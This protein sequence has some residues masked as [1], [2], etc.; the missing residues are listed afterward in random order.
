MMTA[1]VGFAALTV[2][3]G[4]MY[5]A[6]A[7]LQRTADAA[8]LAAAS[9]LIAFDQGEPT[10]L[11][12]QEAIAFA[13]RN[14]V[15]GKSISL[16]GSDVEFGRAVYNE[17]SGAYDF[18]PTDVLPDAVRVRI[19]LEQGS[20]NG[21]LQL[22]FARVF[23]K[24]YA[25][26]TAEAVAMLVPRDIAVVADLS[27]SHNDDSELGNYK[28]TQINLFDVWDALPV[29]K[30]NNGVGN[31]VDPP[32]PGN[33]NSTNDPVGAFPGSP[34]NQ[35]GNGDPGADPQGGGQ[36]GP[37]WGLMYYWGNDVDASYQPS[38][39]PGLY[40]R[41]K[42]QN[43]NDSD[44]ETWYQYAGYSE[45]EINALMA[46]SYD[47]NGAWPYRVAVALGLA[48]WDSGIPGGLW[49]SIPPGHRN[50]GNGNGWVGSGEVEWLVDYPFDS[51]SWID[52]INYTDQ[53]SSSMYRADSGF[54]H[55]LGIKTFVNYLLEKKP[56]H[57]QTAELAE[58]PAQPMQAVKDAT[59][60]L[61]QLLD[62]WE[63]DDQLSLEIY[64]TTA[65]HEVDLTR[66]FEEVSN[67]LT[68]MQAGYYDT[69]TN[70]GGGIQRGIE[71][72]TGARSRHTARKVMILLTDGMANVT[73]NGNTGD[74]Y[75]GR[76][77]AKQMAQQAVDQG[78]RIFCVSVGS[79]ADQAL[80]QEIATLGSGEH[81]HAEG[82]IA[83]YS[84][85]LELIF[86]QL[87][88]TRPVELIR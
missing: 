83:D 58:T 62:G 25:E 48:R 76:L 1:I 35:G 57:D 81:F 5:N 28:Q 86:M 10:E 46:N 19:R 43:W 39:D 3:V 20:A 51:G 32:P 11:A 68:E 49:E 55:R 37:T 34:G 7:D 13:G 36:V 52:F 82:S 64:G 87:G 38:A 60:Q 31:G 29:E 41:P 42:G 16:E 47:N 23:G 4:V 22:Y 66:D 73:A 59:A 74:Y 80:M 45:D 24:D 75:N 33:P 9:R 56:E 12:R 65:R 78:I 40:Y 84:A 67:R 88:G 53:T 15:F 30:G 14:N 8:A 70:M 21:A 27:G 79:G 6:K 2:D 44:L 18:V 50:N 63:T 61:T 26:M 72:L 77:Y 85:Q 17:Q 54:R 71:E 69:W